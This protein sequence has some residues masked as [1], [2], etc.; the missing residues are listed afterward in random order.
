MAEQEIEALEA[1]NPNSRRVV[2][3]Q[4]GRGPLD[5]QSQKAFRRFKRSHKDRN[6]LLFN[7]K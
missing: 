5:Q 6:A 3:I 2:F 4:D 1:S 7:K